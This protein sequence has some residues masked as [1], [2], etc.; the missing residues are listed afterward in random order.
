[1][2]IVSRAKGMILQPRAE[3]PLIDAEPDGAATLYTTYLIPLAALGALARVIG[4][5]VI[6]VSIPFIG[7][8]R[9]PIMSGLLSALVGLVAMLVGIYVWAMII[10]ALAPT[11][12]GRKDMNSALKLAIYSATPALLAGVLSILPLLGLVQIIAAI[13]GLYLLYI[14]FPVLMKVTPERAAGYTVATVVSGIV[15]GLVFGAAT[16]MLGLG[17]SGLG[18]GRVASDA[19]AA[20]MG[21]NIAAGVLGAATGGTDESRKAAA[22]LVAG[23][24]TAGQ[25]A[26]A[27]ERAGVGQPVTASVGGADAQAA[28]SVGAAAAMLG[29]MVSGGKAAAEPVAF[30]TLES[31]LPASVGSLRRTNASGEKANIGGFSG[32]SAEGSYEQAGGGSV[33]I[34]ISDMVNASGILAMGRMA[35]MVESENDG[36]YEKNVTLDGVKVHEKWRSSGSRSELDGFIG[37]RFMIEVR[38]SGVDVGA[39]EKAFSSIDFG[40]LAAAR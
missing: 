40:K 23:A 19:A 1:M 29:S 13:Y 35:F 28:A 9:V 14:G 4:M 26:E 36:G 5:S 30:Q 17:A 34:K 10:N 20:Q 24:V 21:Q 7:R 18:A 33:S 32:S 11:F 37:D 6:G 3:W 39:V 15:V 25:R 16:A 22:A 8:I 31:L 27:A 12:G 38:G 2:D